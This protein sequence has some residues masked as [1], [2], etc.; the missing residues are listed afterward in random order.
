MERQQGKYHS[1][2]PI[3]KKTRAYY[4]KI[5]DE[6]DT[7]CDGKLS[8]EEV[9]QLA[10]KIDKGVDIKDLTRIKYH[11]DQD[12]DLYL[13]LDEFIPLFDLICKNMAA[14]EKM[15]QQ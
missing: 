9:H 11:L 14:R 4:K 3:D 15:Q 6:V 10:Q 7:N 5:F 12:D 1:E 2:E 8:M 13:D